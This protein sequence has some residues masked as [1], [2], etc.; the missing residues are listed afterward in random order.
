MPL[1]LVIIG[2]D[3]T[4]ARCQAIILTN[5]GLLSSVHFG[6]YVMENLFKIQQ[7]Q[8]KKN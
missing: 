8:K 6:T 1:N 3:K 5:A 7:F 2:L 4:Y